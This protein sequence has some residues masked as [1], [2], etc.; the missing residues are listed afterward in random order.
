M[1][2]SDIEKGERS[3][4]LVSSYSSVMLQGRSPRFARLGGWYDLS[5]VLPLE[6]EEVNT[7]ERLVPKLCTALVY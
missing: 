2:L 3:S 7:P 6:V 5:M 1:A 4:L